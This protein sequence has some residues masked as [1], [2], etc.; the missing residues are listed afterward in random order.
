MTPQQHRKELRSF[1][2]IVGGIFLCIGLWP[3]MWQGTSP[4]LWAVGVG[5]ILSVLG[6][7]LPNSLARIHKGWMFVGHVMGW[8]NTRII[9]GLFFYGILTPMGLMARLMGKDSMHLKPMVNGDASYRV[10][11]ASRRNAHFRQQF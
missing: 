1:G 9:L 11:R 2:L 4:R 8:I 5:A 7:V 10:P 3:V 6:A